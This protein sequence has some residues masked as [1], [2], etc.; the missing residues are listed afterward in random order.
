MY[1]SSSERESTFYEIINLQDFNLVEHLATTLIISTNNQFIREVQWEKVLILVMYSDIL[2]KRISTS[3]CTLYIFNF[4]LFCLNRVKAV[5]QF[6]E[7]RF[8]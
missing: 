1:E 8:L 3:F 7:I 2:K 6:H 5:L 4:V